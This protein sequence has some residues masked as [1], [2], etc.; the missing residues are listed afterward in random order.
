[1]NLTKDKLIKKAFAN[2]RFRQNIFNTGTC[3]LYCD[4][5]GFAVQN[6][7][8]A[9]CCFVY[10]RE[11]NVTA[12]KL[13]I[14]KDRGSNYGELL[15]ILYSLEIL[16]KSLSEHQPKIAVIYTD[17]SSISRILSRSYFQ[18]QHDENCRDEILASLDHLNKSFPE[19]QVSIKYISKHKKNNYL[20]RIA[21]NAAREA[22]SQHSGVE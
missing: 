14:E 3:F 18:N 5:A 4:Y 13:I 1:M 21:H 16:T 20:H 19:V 2:P 12:K 10:N 7:Y 6:N 22:A 8:G 15:A 9:A 11:I 17:C